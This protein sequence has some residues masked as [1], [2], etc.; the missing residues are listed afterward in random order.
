MSEI[1]VDNIIIVEK[2]AHSPKRLF[3]TWSSSLKSEKIILIAKFTRKRAIF[4]AK[5]LSYCVQPG[6]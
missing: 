6:Y 5:A 4:S 1:F 3:F 2:N